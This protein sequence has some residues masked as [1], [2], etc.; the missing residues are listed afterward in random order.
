MKTKLLVVASALLL[1]GPAIAQ[2]PLEKSGT[3][4]TTTQNAPT[5]TT[6]GAP[7]PLGQAGTAPSRT[8]P[9]QQAATPEPLDMSALRKSR[10]D[11]KMVNQL[12]ADVDTVEDM[13]IFDANGRKIAEVEGV[14]EDENGQIVGLI[15]EHG[16]FL[17]IGDTES[18]LTF[19]QVQLKNGDLVTT[20]VEEDLPKLPVWS[21]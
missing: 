14:I 5:T 19:D 20:L 4:P 8:A 7:E 6:P 11:D 12:G 1:A 13:D 3:E 2:E 17:G 16:G 18:I 9:Q 10:D 21:R 15:I